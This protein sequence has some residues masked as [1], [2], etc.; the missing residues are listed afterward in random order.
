M[1]AWVIIVGIV[2]IL[3]NQNGFIGI[4]H[5]NKKIVRRS[6]VYL[7]SAATGALGVSLVFRGIILISDVIP[8]ITLFVTNEFLKSIF[9]KKVEK[10]AVLLFFK[11]IADLVI[12]YFH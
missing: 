2:T 10:E 4:H 5:S 9:L 12:S 3:F 8:F 7:L 11:Y 6:S 1:F